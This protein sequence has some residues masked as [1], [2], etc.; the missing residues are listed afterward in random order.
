MTRR[1]I[2]TA[3]ERWLGYLRVLEARDA[4]T[5]RDR[6]R[7]LAHDV[8]RPVRLWTARNPNT[9]PDALT[10]LSTDPDETVGWNVLLNRSTPLEGLQ[11]MADAET[12]SAPADW[13]IVRHKVAHHP[14]TSAELRSQLLAVGVCRPP[15][16]QSCSHEQMYWNSRR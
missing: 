9:P 10:I 1:E 14:N 11:A 8:I 5:T 7:E 16:T 4:K 2:R 12:A 3:H 6:L 15:S 13:F